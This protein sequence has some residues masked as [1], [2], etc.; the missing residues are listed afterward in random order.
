M[1]EASDI[2][3]DESIMHEISWW[4]YLFI[5]KMADAARKIFKL[6]GASFF[7]TL[8]LSPNNGVGIRDAGAVPMMGRCGNIVNLTYDLKLAFARYL[9]QN[10][11]IA[12]LK[13][14][15]IDKVFRQRRILGIHPKEILECNFDIVSSGSCKF[16]HLFAL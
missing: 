2:T 3:F 7:N 6:H 9:A 13:R 5:E 12:C 15:T 11:H 4:Q 1:S 14:Y 8:L 10:P 16:F